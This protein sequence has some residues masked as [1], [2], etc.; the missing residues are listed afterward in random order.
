M[1]APS[2]SKARLQADIHRLLAMLMQRE[3]DDPRLKALTITRLEISK[4]GNLAQVWLHSQHESDPAECLQKLRRLQAHFE[5]ALRRALPRR[6]LPKLK[7][8]LDE[9]YEAGSHVSDLISKLN[10]S[11]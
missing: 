5:H 6:R 4:D 10:T 9:A 2:S 1:P 7:F 11:S 3:I 8:N